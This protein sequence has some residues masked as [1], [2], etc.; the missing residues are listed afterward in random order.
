MTHPP[1]PP[2]QPHRGSTP[3]PQA[4]V[5]SG[6]LA[7]PPDHPNPGRRDLGP[8][9]GRGGA[10]RTI[11]V[12]ASVL[13]LVLAAGGVWLLTSASGGEPQV[14]ASGSATTDPT[15]AQPE[16]PTESAAPEASQTPTE[17]EEPFDQ[18]VPTPG[19]VPEADDSADP[20]I[21]V[22]AQDEQDARDWANANYGSF[23]PLHLK[24]SGSTVVE[25]PEDVTGPAVV[26]YEVGS[27]DV[28][29]LIEFNDAGTPG[30]VLGTDDGTGARDAFVGNRSVSWGTLQVETEGDWQVW[31]QPVGS[32]P[33][34][35]EQ[36]SGPGY[37]LQAGPT[38]LYDFRVTSEDGYI[39]T[40]SVAQVIDDFGEPIKLGE[41]ISEG[42]PTPL[43]NMLSG[44]SVIEVSCQWDWEF[45]A[46]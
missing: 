42:T 20:L 18:A 39:D 22:R 14:V 3:Y 1:Y 5:Q 8:N 10:L 6:S 29:K 37:F 25:M 40:C 27:D 26:T 2:H 24:G 45:V 16:G 38:E 15:E 43:E 23:E 31:I 30:W 7:F 19:A 32:L 11:I 33:M 13:V 36:G 12:V 35:P 4:P 9:R 28:F 41:I 44:P 34:V 21:D 17:P 46:V